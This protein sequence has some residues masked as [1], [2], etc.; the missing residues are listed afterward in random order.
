MGAL[1]GSHWV[2]LVV[3]VV[4][5]VAVVGVVGRLLERRQ[6]GRRRGREQG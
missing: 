2:I 6:S 3:S 4:V 1:T 5:L